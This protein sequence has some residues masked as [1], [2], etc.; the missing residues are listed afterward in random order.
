[1]ST[2][3]RWPQLAAFKPSRK[4]F[5]ELSLYGSETHNANSQFL[6]RLDHFLSGG[7]KKLGI[8]KA[9]FTIARLFRS[10]AVAF[11]V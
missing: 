9:G 5:S 10:T 3:T 4:R 7:K 8:A 11:S 1:L 2:G 6:D